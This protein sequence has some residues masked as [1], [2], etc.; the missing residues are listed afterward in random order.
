MQNAMREV[1]ETMRKKNW[2]AAEVRNNGT[3]YTWPGI[4]HPV[5]RFWLSPGILPGSFRVWIEVKNATQRAILEQELAPALTSALSAKF[6]RDILPLIRPVRERTRRPSVDIRL[7]YQTLL[8]GLRKADGM[9]SRLALATDTV[10]DEAT[11][12]LKGQ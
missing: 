1:R 6:G 11:R 4:K 5:Y 12:I 8:A 10:A 2:K 7:P 3:L 9:S